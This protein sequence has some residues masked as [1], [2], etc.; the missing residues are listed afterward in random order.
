MLHDSFPERE[1]VTVCACIHV[2]VCVCVC[3]CSDMQ[4]IMH[5]C[6]TFILACRSDRMIII[7]YTSITCFMKTSVSFCLSVLLS[8][9]YSSFVSVHAH[10]C[11]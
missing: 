2:C 3:V 1:R 9:L 7:H 11:I 10:V 4:V 8:L 5:S 6:S